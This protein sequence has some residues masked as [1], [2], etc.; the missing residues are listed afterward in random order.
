MADRSKSLVEEW[1][2]RA[3]TALAE[4]NRGIHSTLE[5]MHEGEDLLIDEAFGAMTVA[6]RADIDKDR[7]A[8]EALEA[9]EREEAK[10]KAAPVRSPSVLAWIRNKAWG[11][12]A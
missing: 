6:E 7:A 2:T 1:T 10:R 4:V 11:G 3:R 8:L 5:R 12:R 9:R